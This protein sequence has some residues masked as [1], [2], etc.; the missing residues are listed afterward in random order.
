M[1]EKDKKKINYNDLNNVIGLG[2][3][4]L[5]IIY[6]LII[7]LIVYAATIIGKEWGIIKFLLNLL[8][9]L[10]PLFI[11][12]VMAW[13][14]DP[15]VMWL[16]K[17]K[18]K[19]LWGSAILYGLILVI[20]G[21]SITSFIPIIMDQINELIKAIPGIFDEV[22]V[23]FNNL[24][25]GLKSNEYVNFETTKADIILSIQNIAKSLTTTLPDKVLNMINGMFSAFGT[26]T[27]GLLMGFY[28]LFDYDKVKS[29]INSMIPKKYKGEYTELTTD[30]NT[31]LFGFVKGMVFSSGI[32]F[33]CAAIVLS[34]IGLKA[35]LLFALI[36][37][38][39]NVIPYIG[40]YLGIIPAA[41]VGFTQS[42]AIGLLVII[43]MGIIQL[44]EG[45]IINPLIMSKTMKLS[46]TTILVSMLIFGYLFGMLG[47]LIA[48]PLAAA[49]KVIYLFVLK[50]YKIKKGIFNE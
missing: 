11:G 48:A 21:L 35:P 47:V 42:S 19:R 38:I 39:L 40:P 3:K 12:L 20:I 33:I 25:N 32:V 2:G 34:I 15:V 14:L 7:I 17:K 8:K 13:L 26:F 46:P 22:G 27:L 6:V 37:A 41:I 18:I 9:A 45:N 28:L 5:K 1:K 4:I 10:T 36:A 49:L 31:S 50:K 44:I 23:W 29:K 43:V 24:F 16:E 30:I